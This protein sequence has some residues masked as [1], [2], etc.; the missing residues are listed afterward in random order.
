V[1]IKSSPLTPTTHSFAL[2]AKPTPRGEVRGS[3]DEELTPDL[4][5]PQLCSQSKAHS[6][7]RREGARPGQVLTHDL[8]D[9]QLCLQSKAHSKRRREG[10]RADQELTP[11]IHYS[12]LCP[13]SKALCEATKRRDGEG[14]R[15]RGK[16]V[17]LNGMDLQQATKVDSRRM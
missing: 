1:Q 11:D 6:K 7:R 16:G 10:A 2:I 14:R 8:K 5:D 15:L 9:P 4:H 13:Q 3:A 12:Q 17:S